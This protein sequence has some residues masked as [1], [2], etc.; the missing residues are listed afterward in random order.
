MDAWRT[1]YVADRWVDL[2]QSLMPGS[3][4]LTFTDTIR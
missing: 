1:N 2:S 3:V 4:P